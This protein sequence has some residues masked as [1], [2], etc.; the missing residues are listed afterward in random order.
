VYSVGPSKAAFQA[1]CCRPEGAEDGL[2]SAEKDVQKTHVNFAVAE[3]QWNKLAYIR[4][5]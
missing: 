3:E 4:E 1:V 2:G 5:I